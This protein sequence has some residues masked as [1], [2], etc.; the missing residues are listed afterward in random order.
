[1]ALRVLGGCPS[2]CRS[3]SPP[4]GRPRGAPDLCGEGARDHDDD[5]AP[6]R[7]AEFVEGDPAV[8]A[9]CRV[10]RQEGLD[11]VTQR[12]RMLRLGW[13]PGS[14]GGPEGKRGVVSE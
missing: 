14:D 7:D 5:W 3:P 4:G 11:Q 10:L 9:L 13:W 2:R 8:G 1:M 12:A 6:E